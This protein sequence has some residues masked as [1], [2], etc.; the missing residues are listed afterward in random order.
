MMSGVSTRFTAYLIV[1]GLI[2]V[3]TNTVVDLVYG[4]VN[5]TVKLARPHG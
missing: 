4:L 2:F 1:V 3:I 5:P